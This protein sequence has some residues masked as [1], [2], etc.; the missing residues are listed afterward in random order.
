MTSLET[1]QGLA[2]VG[3]LFMLS[4]LAILGAALINRT[5]LANL[6]S[7]LD[8]PARLSVAAGFSL[9]M[10][11]FGLFLQAAGNMAAVNIGPGLTML[12]LA[13]AF[14]LLMF[15]MLD[16]TIADS[17]N[18]RSAVGERAHDDAAA[19]PA[20]VREAIREAEGELDKA[21]ATEAPKIALVSAG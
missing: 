11:A 12:L 1:P 4:G 13:L 3:S 9:P 15:L 18:R 21:Q 19:L 7:S 14:G 8:T 5:T 2:V 16:E 20:P 10:I 6:K 17:M